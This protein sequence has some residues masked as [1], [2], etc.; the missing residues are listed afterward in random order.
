M[1]TEQ[2]RRGQD[3]RQLPVRQGEGKLDLFARKALPVLE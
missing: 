1:L 2:Q 3:R